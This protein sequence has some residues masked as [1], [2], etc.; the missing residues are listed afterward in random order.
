MDSK[1][2][3]LKST[4]RDL[5]ISK[6]LYN[7]YKIDIVNF[8]VYEVGFQRVI[9]SVNLK[10]GAIICITQDTKTLATKNNVLYPDLRI[11]GE[12]YFMMPDSNNGIYFNVII[13]KSFYFV[14][15]NLEKRYFSD[16]DYNITAEFS[17][18]RFST[19]E[20]GSIN[21]SA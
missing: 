6:L 20:F 16:T 12:N 5:Y 2:C 8:K 13:D 4:C 15:V 11:A 17:D 1:N 10:K 18:Q 9:Y 14:I 7:D 3:G 21:T 19:T